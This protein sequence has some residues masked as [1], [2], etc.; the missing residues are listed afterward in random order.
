MCIRDSAR[1]NQEVCD[2]VYQLFYDLEYKLLIAWNSLLFS[3]MHRWRIMQGEGMENHQVLL[4]QPLLC[5]QAWKFYLQHFCCET[6]DSSRSF[7][8][9]V[10]FL[11]VIDYLLSQ[12]AAAKR[13]VLTKD[14]YVGSTG[15]T[16]DL[17][18]T[19]SNVDDLQANTILN[20]TRA[21]FLKLNSSKCEL[22]VLLSLHLMAFHL[23]PFL[24]TSNHLILANVWDS[25]G[26][27]PC[28]RKY[29]LTTA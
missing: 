2:I 1:V 10:L 3:P 19:T 26:P 7:L 27:Q 6:G 8:S 25:G 20:F 14:I 29:L 18:S 21:N 13:G 23:S 22:L 15:H 17:R 5:S 11:L 9:P 12:L 28:H 4:W 24:L 16:D